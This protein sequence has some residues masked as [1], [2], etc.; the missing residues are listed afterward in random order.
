MPAVNVPDSRE[1]SLTPPPPEKNTGKGTQR[2][3]RQGATKNPTPAP[4]IPNKR[5]A[6]QAFH[7]AQS[8]IVPDSQLQN[9][10]AHLERQVLEAKKAALQK[11]LQALTAAN[12]VL[13]TTTNPVPPTAASP[14]VPTGAPTANPGEARNSNFG[15][16][17]EH[18]GEESHLVPLMREYRS[19]D[20]QYIRD[21]KKN[22][23][24]PE[25]IMK[26]STSVRRT[27]EAAKSL[28]IGTNGLE[29]EAKEEDCT[30]ADVKGIIP[31]LR[32]FHVYTQILVFLAAPGNKLQLQLA[33]GRYAEHLM[34]L[35]E[36]YTW[37]SVRAYHFDFHQAR[38]LEGIDDS[39]AWKTPDHELKQYLLV[40][41]PTRN[42][43]SHDNRN[44]QASTLSPSSTEVCFKWNAEKDCPAN[45][46]FLHQCT[47]CAGNHIKRRCPSRSTTSGPNNANTTPVGRR[48]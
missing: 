15:L 13:P 18:E 45:C 4:Q 46:R 9:E 12:P 8:D 26:L 5:T 34:M 11:Q 6:D 48:Q 25:N 39:L 30:I 14:A 28:K 22:K 1:N 38:I 29:I 24:K 27:R 36:M 3:T 47:N 40:P 42:T 16:F 35:W 10:V 17:Y 33:L 19:V 31:L 32:A 43:N 37:D 2:K 23:F 21:I 20:I 44:S 41:R 7:D